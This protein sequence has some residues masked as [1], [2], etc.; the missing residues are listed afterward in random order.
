MLFGNEYEIIFKS[1]KWMNGNF[2]SVL[3]TLFFSVTWCVAACLS[4]CV[5]LLSAVLLLTQNRL[6]LVSCFTKRLK[7]QL[8]IFHPQHIANTLC[9]H[10]RFLRNTVPG[11]KNTNKCLHVTEPFCVLL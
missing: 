2:C 6:Q 3:L 5:H 1:R 10:V 7:V 11:W 4:V 8:C 9:W